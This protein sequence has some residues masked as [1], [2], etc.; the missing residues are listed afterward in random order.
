MVIDWT[1]VGWGAFAFFAIMLFLAPFFLWLWDTDRFEG[2][3]E[4]Y[5]LPALALLCIYHG[6]RAALVEEWLWSALSIG[7][8]IVLIV[9]LLRSRHKGRDDTV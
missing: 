8:A 9:D 6:V 5:T 1:M 2:W 3:R 4:R 7:V